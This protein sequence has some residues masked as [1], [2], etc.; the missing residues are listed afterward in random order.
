MFATLQTKF[1]ILIFFN[2]NFC[3]LIQI[4]LQF[5]PKD[6]IVSKSVLVQVM[7]WHQTGKKP[8]SKS[9]MA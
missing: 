5:V 6:S 9:M 4:S 3:I 1:E 8:L 7:A 2:E